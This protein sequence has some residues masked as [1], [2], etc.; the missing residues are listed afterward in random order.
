MN[1]VTDSKGDRRAFPAIMQ[2]F[3]V[4]RQVPI[5]VLTDA[6]REFDTLAHAVEISEP[7]SDGR[8]QVTIGLYLPE[9]GRSI[10]VIRAANRDQ[11]DLILA[12][13]KMRHFSVQVASTFTE[14]PSAGLHRNGHMLLTAFIHRLC[15]AAGGRRLQA[16]SRSAGASLPPRRRSQLSPSPDAVSTGRR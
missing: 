8:A 13:A 15:S 14:F 1:R 4:E 10:S 2:T 11:L 12:T 16:A 5:A 3:V 7:G 9:A 6:R